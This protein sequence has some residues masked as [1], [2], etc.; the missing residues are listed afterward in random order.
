M[1]NK[2][3]FTFIEILAVIIVISLV[4]VLAIPQIQKISV[5]SKIKLCKNK[6]NLIEENVNL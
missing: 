3:G 4:A 2:K 6:L 5:N 1:K